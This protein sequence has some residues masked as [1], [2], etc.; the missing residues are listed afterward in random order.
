MGTF[1]K[2][3]HPTIAQRRTRELFLSFLISF[4]LVIECAERTAAGAPFITGLGMDGNICPRKLNFQVGFKMIEKIVRMVR[5]ISAPRKKRSP[6][7]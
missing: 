7:R 3:K 2:K 5:L 6:Q 1:S 4:I